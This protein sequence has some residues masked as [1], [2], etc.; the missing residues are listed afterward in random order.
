MAPSSSRIG[1]VVCVIFGCDMPVVLRRN[2]GG[3]YTFVGG[4]YADGIMYGEA[5]E[6]L[7]DGNNRVVELRIH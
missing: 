6:G 1:D 3:P 5:M 4:C 7:A 2:K